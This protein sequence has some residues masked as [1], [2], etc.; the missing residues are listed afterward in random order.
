[1]DSRVNGP[2]LKKPPTPFLL[3]HSGLT[4]IT[5]MSENFPGT[6]FPDTSCPGFH[7]QITEHFSS[8]KV[9][10]N[11]QKDRLA[12][13]YNHMHSTL[14]IIGR[15]QNQQWKYDKTWSTEYCTTAMYKVSRYCFM[16]SFKT[17]YNTC[18]VLSLFFCFPLGIHQTISLPQHLP[19]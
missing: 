11:T 2:F 17:T 12:F 1:M 4:V 16:I 6:L 13:K 15:R 5:M 19:G 14:S 9:F 8:E 18:V 10:R 7:L 3:I